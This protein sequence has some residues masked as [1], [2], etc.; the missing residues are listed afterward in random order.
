VIPPSEPH[1]A[2]TAAREA[3]RRC[4]GDPD[5]FGRELWG[6]RPLH[7]RSGSGPGF[8]DLLSLDDVDH[9][10][11]SGG[12][13]QPA[14]RLVRGGQTLPQAAYTKTTRTGSQAATG[15]ADAAAV[16]REFAEGATIV[17][18]GMHRWWAPLARFCRLLESA[19]GHPVQANA[20]VT[21]P[22]SQGLAV[23]E[24]EHDVFVLQSHGTK[25]WQVFDRGDRPPTGTPLVDSD[26]RPGD[27]LY[28]PRA[29]PHAA[30]T[31]AT[32]SVH[33]T[34]GI[35]AMTWRSVLGEVVRLADQAEWLDDP[36][37]L[38]FADD[39]GAWS[40][41]LRLAE[42]GDWVAK[43][44]PDVIGRR[45]R[46]R[47][48]TERQPVLPGQLRHVL[49]LGALGDHSIVR[50]RDT[51]LCSFDTIDGELSVLLGDR[52][53]RMPVRL[54]RPLRLLASGEPV[55]VQDLDRHLDEA[56]RLVLVR[57]LVV[58]GLLEVVG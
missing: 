26:L 29:F 13:R 58:E 39:P 27:S 42:I 12:L 50:R 11:A 16:F 47:F 53:L 35:L 31:Q 1:P 3:L 38:R 2:E 22:G 6:R 54:E 55:E 51:A 18:Q 25:H 5:R 33:V 46:R 49:D 7:C 41:T 43:T 4:V 30:S 28:I 20:Y 8:D 36:L 19:L 57:R 40:E 17:F 34:V 56:G 44:D 9:L 15:V 32:A 14:F 24:D 21:P 52:E 48:L 10:V 45:L 23:H 37:P